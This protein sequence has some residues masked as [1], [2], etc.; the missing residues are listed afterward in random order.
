MKKI[1]G[2]RI[3]G[4]GTK[5]DMAK[6]LKLI[7]INLENPYSNLDVKG[8]AIWEDDILLTLISEKV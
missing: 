4:D 8:Q 1:Y 3:T 5:E 2:I 7:I 6:S